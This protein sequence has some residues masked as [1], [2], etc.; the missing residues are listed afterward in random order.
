MVGI[1]QAVV[2]WVLTLCL[3]GDAV[4]SELPD[5]PVFTVEVRNN[6]HILFKAAQDFVTSVLK[7]EAAGLSVT[8]VSTYKPT[9]YRTPESFLLCF[10]QHN[11]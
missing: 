1:V 7:M 3:F 5:T 4:V 8:T 2:A 10:T 11:G 6:V 9:W